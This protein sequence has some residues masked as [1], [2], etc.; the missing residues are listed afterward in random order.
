[1]FQLSG[2]Y[3]SLSITTRVADDTG[4]GGLVVRPSKAGAA[5]PVP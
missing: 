1:M 5:L 3:C 4:L 2:C